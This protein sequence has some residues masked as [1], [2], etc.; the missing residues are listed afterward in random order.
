MLI[1]KEVI[2]IFGKGPTQSL[3]DTAMTAETDYSVNF[4][5]QGKDFA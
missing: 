2:S 4:S 3:D 1:K 5:E